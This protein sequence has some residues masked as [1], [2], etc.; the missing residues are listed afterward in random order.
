MRDAST[1]LRVETYAHDVTLR[2]GH[3]VGSFGHFQ[4]AGSHSGAAE[5]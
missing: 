5:V 3:G 4:F 1:A 2:A